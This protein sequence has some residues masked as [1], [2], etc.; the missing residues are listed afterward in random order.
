M[1]AQ[2]DRDLDDELA[3]HVAE[4]ARLRIDRGA[5]P[6]DAVRAARLAFGNVTFAKEETRGVWVS[7]ATERL[8]QD[9]RFG[10]RIVTGAPLLLLLAVT[11]VALVI[12]G[13]TT[14]YSVASAILNKPAPGVRAGNLITLSWI[15]KDGF[16]EPE[17]SYANYQDLA[18]QSR[19]LGPMLA[20]QYVRVA[21]GHENG[22]NG[23]WAAGVSANYFQAL[24]VPIV[25]GRSFTADEDQRATS[26]L[27]MVISDRAWRDYFAAAPSAVGAPVLIS[28]LPATIVGVAAPDFRGTQLAPSVDAWVPIVPFARAA[29]GA[30]AFT[31]RQ[32][33]E[34]VSGPLVGNFVGVLA[35]LKNGSSLTEARAEITTLWERLQSRYTDVSQ[36]T[37]VAV[38]SHSA[39][40]GG[41]SAIST[42]GTTFLAIFSVITA[43]TLVIV[44]A[45]VANLLLAAPRRG[46]G[47]WPCDSPWA[48]HEPVSS[49]MLIAEGLVIA[50][51]ASAA[52]YVFTR[53]MTGVIASL[54]A[55]MVPPAVPRSSPFRIG[56][57]RPTRCC[58]RS[59]A[60]RS[61]AWHPRRAP[62]GSR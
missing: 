32:S 51:L 48:R 16:I 45:N 50:L 11:L 12:G 3:F 31:S 34:G 15:R 30:D 9:L 42:Q 20:Y 41:N 58:S 40:A 4:E 57:W 60:W 62:G 52:A 23:I 2:D 43:L 49:R 27:P 53:W 25:I 26:G 18:A 38:L 8:F 10:L 19:S 17:T 33:N 44:C 37:A 61:S 5:S 54:V 47:N 22:S 14:V 36:D 28:G 59:S 39:T 7:G 35:Q 1:R 6:A 56:E 55:P 46:S 21:L 24:E 29:G 13:N